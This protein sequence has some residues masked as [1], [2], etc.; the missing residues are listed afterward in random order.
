MTSRVIEP[1]KKIVPAGFRCCI[2]EGETR[3]PQQ[4]EVPRRGRGRRAGQTTIRET[5]KHGRPA[6]LQRPNPGIGRNRVT[7]SSISCCL[8]AAE[9]VNYE[10]RV[11]NSG[12]RGEVDPSRRGRESGSLS[13]PI[14]PME[15]R[16]T[17]K[18]QEPGSRE[19]GRP[20]VGTD[21]GIHPLNPPRK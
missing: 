18:R 6:I 12:T 9:E 1:R 17:E 10:K 8:T 15:S 14:V 11:V 5:M 20:R 7:T 2:D 3:G 4:C 16:R 13:V 21:A 19:G